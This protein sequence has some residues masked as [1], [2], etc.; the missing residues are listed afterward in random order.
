[1]NVRRLLDP[2]ILEIGPYAFE[3]V[4][5]FTCTGTEINN[6]NYVTELQ[7]QIYVILTSRS[8]LN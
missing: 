3:H 1:M 5:T 2:L 7:Q 4:H 8:I 6:K